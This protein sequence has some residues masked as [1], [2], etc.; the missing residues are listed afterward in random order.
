V[1]LLKNSDNHVN[2][3]GLPVTAGAPVFI[4]SSLNGSTCDIQFVAASLGVMAEPPVDEDPSGSLYVKTCDMLVPSDMRDFMDA[5]KVLLALQSMGTNSN[6]L[7]VRVE[8]AEEGE[9]P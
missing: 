2:P 8:Y 5:S 3:P 4:P 9:A 6:V 1:Q 7:C